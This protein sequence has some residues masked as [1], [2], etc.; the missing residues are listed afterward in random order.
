MPY[1]D[2]TP[3]GWICPGL[4]WAAGYS[5]SRPIDEPVDLA[6]ENLFLCQLDRLVPTR[7]SQDLIFSRGV[8]LQKALAP[9]KEPGPMF[10][11]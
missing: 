9:E 1:A 2:I 8:L 11:I 7:D 3:W 10:S 6:I 5:D 4:V